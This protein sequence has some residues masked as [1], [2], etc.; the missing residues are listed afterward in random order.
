MPPTTGHL[1][2]A[3]FADEIAWSDGNGHTDVLV[4]TQPFEPFPN[5]RVKALRYAL[6]GCEVHHFDQEIPQDPTIE[7]FWDIWKG[8]LINYGVTSDTIIV[9]S[10]PY[11]QKLAEIMGAKF[12][13]YD[14]DRCLNSVKATQVREHPYAYFDQIIPEFQQYLSTRVTIFG[15]ES[16]GKTTLAKK[17]SVQY[18][19]PGLFE[20]ARPY[21]EH[22]VNEITADS[23]ETIWRGQYAL[24]RQGG[25]INHK[26]I[27]IQDTDLYS[28]IGYWELPHWRKE[29]G[30]VPPDLIRDAKALQSDLYLITPSNI[31]FEA[32]PLRYGGD[33]REGSDAYWVRVCENYGLPY[34]LLSKDDPFERALE[35]IKLINRKMD[36]KLAQIAYDRH[37]L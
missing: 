1:Q 21:L 18:G 19:C 5:E 2:L 22:T 20:W 3:Q 12:M 16:T 25:I 36:S 27:L 37:G 10:E 13:P 30:P 14:I 32:D 17:L 11:G 33:H 35:A 34:F 6:E 9:A 23:M 29:L 26:P 7:G 24:Q 28:T 31:P 8:I 4:C 15:A